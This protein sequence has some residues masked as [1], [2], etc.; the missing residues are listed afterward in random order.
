MLTLRIA[1]LFICAMKAAKSLAFKSELKL[2][3]LDFDPSDIYFAHGCV[4]RP[5]TGVSGGEALDD[6]LL[7]GKTDSGIK[8]MVEKFTK[9][10]RLNDHTWK[11]NYDLNTWGSWR[12]FADLVQILGNDVTVIEAKWAPRRCPRNPDPKHVRQLALYTY[13]LCSRYRGKAV[14]PKL[15]YF[16]GGTDKC[17][18]RI[19]TFEFHAGQLCGIASAV[20]E[21]N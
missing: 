4:F 19:K 17:A 14:H 5:S 7:K 16:Y 9:K 12:G 21:L 20:M 8:E 13:A 3:N 6:Y 18:P 15:V 1:Q 10:V 2:Y 11:R